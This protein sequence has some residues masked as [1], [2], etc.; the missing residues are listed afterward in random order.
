[1]PVAR[2]GGWGGA[3]PETAFLDAV[4]RGCKGDDDFPTMTFRAMVFRVMV[5][6]AAVFRAMVFRAM[7][8]RAMM[9]WIVA[10]PEGRVKSRW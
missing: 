3:F 6:R 2:G 9:N 5:F 1:M 10:S 4:F 7:I 8:F